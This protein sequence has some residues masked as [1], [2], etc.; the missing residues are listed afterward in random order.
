MAVR[1]AIWRTCVVDRG[2]KE[3][4][5]WQSDDWPCKCCD[6]CDEYRERYGC[7]YDKRYEGNGAVEIVGGIKC[8]TCPQYLAN[9]PFVASVYEYLADYREGRLGSVR[10][11]PH[12]LLQYLRVAS[13][14]LDSWLQA[15]QRV[16][17]RDRANG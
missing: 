14:E 15:Q 4:P 6:C 2:T 3:Q 16:M 13:A 11:M 17:L 10:E 9:Q 7:G 12:A 1:L 5:D 8:T